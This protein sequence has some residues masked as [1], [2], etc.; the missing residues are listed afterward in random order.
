M[1]TREE[2]EAK[3]FDMFVNI[4][5]ALKLQSDEIIKLRERVKQLEVK[6]CT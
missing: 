1:A 5:A 2:W 4:H 3:V 6:K